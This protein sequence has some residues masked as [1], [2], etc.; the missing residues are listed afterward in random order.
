MIAR[1]VINEMAF[2]TKKTNR[3]PI[4]WPRFSIFLLFWLMESE[5]LPIPCLSKDIKTKELNL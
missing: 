4:N 2:F 1:Y 5:I 3:P